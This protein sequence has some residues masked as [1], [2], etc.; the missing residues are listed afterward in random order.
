MQPWRAFDH[1]FFER[2]QA[3]LVRALDTPLVGRWL[4]WLLCIRPTDVGYHG[5]IVRLLPHA[6]IVE[7]DDHTFTLDARTHW[8]YS[9]RLYHAFKLVW[10]ACHAW[11]ALIAERFAPALDSGF[12]TLT[13]YPDKHPETTTVHGH[14]RRASAGETFAAIRSGAGTSADDA[15][16]SESFVFIQQAGAVW[17]DIDRSIFL[18]DTSALTSGVTVTAATL[19]VF[20]TSLT[21][22]LSGAKINVFAS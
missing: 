14:A 21:T 16:A 13:K 20:A 3:L 9:K 18:F 2:H 19:N 10:W 17:V 4:R 7:H 22:G 11:D 5:R 1:A 8:K 6:Y 15:G 12:A